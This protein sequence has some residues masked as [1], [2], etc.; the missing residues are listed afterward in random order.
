PGDRGSGG[1][2]AS[3]PGDRGSG[4]CEASGPGDRGSG[5][6]EA[7]GPGD[8]GS[9][10][11]RPQ[12]QGTEGLWGVRPQDQGT[13]GLGGVRPQDQGTEG[14]GGVRPQDQGTE[15]LGG[16]RPQDQGT[17]GL[18]G[19]RPQD[20]GT[21]GLGGVR[22]Q[23]QGTEGLGG[24]RPQDQG[25]EGLGGVMPQNQGTEGL[26]GEASEPN[27]SEV[28]QPQTN[29]IHRLKLLGQTFTLRILLMGQ[30]FTLRVLLVGQTVTL[31]VLLVGQ[32]FTLRVL[33]L[34]QTFTLR[35]LLVG[36]TFT[37]RVLLMG[38]T[39]T[40]RVLLVGQTFT[41]RVLLVGQTVTLRVLLV[42]QILTLRVL[43]VQL[44]MVRCLYVV[45]H[46]SFLNLNK[47]LDHQPPLAV[48]GG[49]GGGGGGGGCKGGLYKEEKPAVSQHLDLCQSTTMYLHLLILL[50][51]LSSAGASESGI[52]GG[53]EAKP[54]SRPYMVS[55]QHRGYRVCGGM[56][57]R[58]DF[59]MTSAHCLKNAYPLTVVLGAHDLKKC[60]KSCQKIQVS[61]YHRH[62]LHENI[63][64]N[65]YDILL[66]KL[67]TT[68]RLTD[69]V[70]VIGLPKDDENIPAATKCSVAGWGK[71]NSNN[72]HGSDVLM[73]VAVMMEDNSECKRVWQEP[74]DKKQMICTRTNGGKG[75]C[76]G[77]S[78]GPLICNNKAQ[79]I[80]AFNYAER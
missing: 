21:E 7:S 63:T 15:G 57:I 10:G 79:G 52:V 76:Q 60:K 68:A 69:N 80:V 54:H 25:T 46:Q 28:P 53:K 4:G 47:L 65:S 23:D 51:L 40:L 9:G 77:D 62:P 37:L 44:D 29:Y 58:E 78:G 34:G 38:Q 36:Q 1:C 41:L 20:Q 66:L 35:D 2:E 16:V 11:V 67:K 70:T 33:L 74:F 26:G 48:Y 64:Q 61:H 49:R 42:G 17:E 27:S 5:G 45:L 71:T 22:P 24:V 6:C 73:E 39:F 31:R 72:K 3:G 30:T 50:Q 55:L 12:D 18:G 8:R 75:F 43:L 32:T 19:V 56:L 13:E 14:L 59:V